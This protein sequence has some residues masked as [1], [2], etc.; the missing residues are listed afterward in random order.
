MDH[1]NPAFVECM[2]LLS[3]LGGYASRIKGDDW[4]ATSLLQQLLDDADVRVASGLPL[5]L[6]SAGG[7][8]PYEI[9]VYES[10]ELE[11][12]DRN[13]HDFFNVLVWL[14]FPRAKAAL[15]A[16]HY[17]AWSDDSGNGRG[18]VRDALTLFD[19]SGMVVL[20]AQP[21]LLQLIRNFQWKSLF[22]EQRSVLHAGMRFLPFGHALCEKALL[23]YRGMTGHAVLL[24]VDAEWLAPGAAQLMPRV[25]RL[26][27]ALVADPQAMQTTRQLSPLPVLGVPGWCREN[28]SADYYDDTRYFRPGRRATAAGA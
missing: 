11:V 19:E 13:W 9:R 10:A 17:A 2:P 15:N 27:E 21:A 22:W 28:E 16:R 26:L 1:W 23:P 5:Q 25:D 20:S 14:M 12:R 8:L 18:T 4:P 7:K 6:V 3:P 24:D